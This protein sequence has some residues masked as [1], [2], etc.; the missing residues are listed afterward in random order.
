MVIDIHSHILPGVDD[1]AK[2]EE[3]SIAMAQAA[4]AQGIHTIV[5]TPH[6]KNGVFENTKPSIMTSVSILQELLM[7]EDIPLTVL[8]GQ[9]I[10]LNGDMVED[11]ENDDLLSLNHSKYIFVELPT[12]SVPRYTNQMMYN[13]QMQGYTPLIV[14]PERNEELLEHPSKLYDLVQKGVITQVTAGSIIGKFGKAVQ[15]FSMQLIESNLTHFIASDAHNTSSR[16]FCM[17]EAFQAVK[18]QFGMDVYYVFMENSQL[19]INNQ[20]I[21]KIEP[22]RVRKK[23]FFGIF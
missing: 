3:D 13:L 23:K 5:A 1:G 4:A 15:K 17:Q 12:S 22:E 7:Q 14:H 16:G 9:E 18:D 19:A 10:R 6:H 20:N 8:P 11:I 21:N 2:S